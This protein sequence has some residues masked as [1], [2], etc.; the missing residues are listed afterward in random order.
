LL[1]RALQWKRLLLR[2]T[3]WNDFQSASQPFCPEARCR[4]I[5]S[6]HLMN[7][8][9]DVAVFLERAMA[10]AKARNFAEP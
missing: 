10:G 2:P 1:A 8:T 3:R 4:W 5:S 6:R 9:P 7:I